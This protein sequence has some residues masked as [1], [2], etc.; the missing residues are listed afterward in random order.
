MTNRANQSQQKSSPKDVSGHT[1]PLGHHALTPFYDAA[2]ALLTRET[3]WRSRL[4][5]A[6]DPQPNDRILDV[7][8]GTGSL[9]ILV[10][11]ASPKTL[12]EGVDPDSDAVRR[13]R[14][15]ARRHGSNATF[16]LGYLD[17]DT[18]V[19][20]SAPN[21]ITSSLVLH[22]T[23]IAE[24]ARILETMFLILEPGGEL[25]IADYGL[26][27]SKLMKLLFRF[28]VQ[29]IDGVDNTQPNADGALP[30]LISSA[31]FVAVEVC[32]Q[33]PTPTGMISLFRA[34]KPSAQTEGAIT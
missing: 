22:Q 16:H 1:P 4:V 17:T 20:G 3:T 7:G 19:G 14:E 10:Y 31:G 5:V 34:A 30:E 21:K 29:S 6:I 23:P 18:L 27:N 11:K 2:I 26:Q 32:D 15:K 8:S 28:T 13:A 12:F 33:I 25:H 9:A 24:K